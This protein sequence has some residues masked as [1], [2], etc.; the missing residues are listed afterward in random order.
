[1]VRFSK[2]LGKQG[3][4]ERLLWEA[5]SHTGRIIFFRVAKCWAP[6]TGRGTRPLRVQ[7]GQEGSF[8][9]LPHLLGRA[10]RN[11]FRKLS[12]QGT[13]F[14]LGLLFGGTGWGRNSI[15]PGCF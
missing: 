6:A 1:M 10:Q 8:S 7:G 12:G 5:E 15:L 9:S 4:K 14:P 11:L 2:L 3:G 13:D